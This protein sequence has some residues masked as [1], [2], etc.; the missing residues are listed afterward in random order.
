M[1]RNNKS[2]I[3]SRM[4]KSVLPPRA[5][6]LNESNPTLKPSNSKSAKRPRSPTNQHPCTTMLPQT[7]PSRSISNNT[8]H[9]AP[10]N[11]NFEESPRPNS[12][13]I[14]PNSAH[15]Q[16]AFSARKSFSNSEGRIQHNPNGRGTDASNSR[17]VWFRNPSIVWYRGHDLRVEDHP[18]LLAAAQRGGPVVSLF[19]WDPSDEFSVCLGDVKKWWLRQSLL[20]LERHLNRLGST[21]FA[22]VGDSTE[23]LRSVISATGADAVF[24]N[25]RYEPDLLHRDERLRTQLVS[26]GLT[27]ESFKSELIVEPWELTCSS[28]SPRFQDF[29]SY[30]PRWLNLPSPPLPLPS[31][32]RLKRLGFEVVSVDINDLGLEVS[33]HV[34]DTLAEIWRPGNSNGRSVLQCF[35]DE[36]F[37]SFGN[38]QKRRNAMGTSRLS[39]YIRFGEISPR[40]LF[41]SVLLHVTKTGRATSQKIVNE[42]AGRGQA[43]YVDLN[44]VDVEGNAPSRSIPS[45]IQSAAS[46]SSSIRAFLKNLCLRDF[47][48]HTLFHKP[49]FDTEPLIPEFHRFPWA[50]NSGS[51]AAW[52]NGR[53]GYPIVDAA[54][55]NLNCTGWIHNRMRFLLAS[56]LTKQLL[57]PWAKGLRAFYELL[58]DGDQA[59]NALGW[60][61]T[62]GSNTDAFPATY[63][64]NPMKLGHQYNP[65][66]NYIRKWVPELKDLPTQYIHEPWKAPQQVLQSAGVKL[67]SSYPSRIILLSSARQRYYRVLWSMRKVLSQSK[68]SKSLTLSEENV[69]VTECP[70]TKKT[71]E[72]ENS[73]SPGQLD[74]LSSLWSLTPA[75][76]VDSYLFKQPSFE[77]QFPL[78]DS[79][80]LDDAAVTIP[81]GDQHES[82]GYTLL[83]A[84]GVIPAASDLAPDT[85]NIL[86]DHFIT[87]NIFTDVVE[88]SPTDR[89]IVLRKHEDQHEA[90]VSDDC[91]LENTRT[92]GNSGGLTRDLAAGLE[93]SL[94]GVEQLHQNKKMSIEQRRDFQVSEVL[95]SPP[96]DG[97]ISPRKKIR[98]ARGLDPVTYE[99]GS[100]SRTNLGLG[101]LPNGFGNSGGHAVPNYQP[102]LRAHLSPNSLPIVNKGSLFPTSSA[103]TEGMSSHFAMPANMDRISADIVDNPEMLPS[104]GNRNSNTEL[105]G[106]AALENSGIHF[107]HRSKF[108]STYGPPF[109]IPMMEMHPYQQIGVPSMDVDA[110]KSSNLLPSTF[111]S[112]PGGMYDPSRAGGSGVPLGFLPYTMPHV[113]LPVT[114][115]STMPSMHPSYAPL[116]IPQHMLSHTSIPV[117]PS[118]SPHLSQTMAVSMDMSQATPGA[119]KTNEMPTITKET[120]F[121][122]LA[123][124]HPQST[125]LDPAFR[126]EHMVKLTSSTGRVTE[127]FKG[128]ASRMKEIGS[129]NVNGH[130][131]RGDSAENLNERPSIEVGESQLPAGGRPS[132][133]AREEFKAAIGAPGVIKR[134]EKIIPENVQR[135]SSSHGIEGEI[136][137]ELPKSSA[138]NLRIGEMGT[139]PAKGKA[140]RRRPR[141]PNKPRNPRVSSSP[142]AIVPV[143]EHAMTIDA[144]QDKFK[145]ASTG[146]ELANGKAR[147]NANANGSKS[148]LNHSGTP[149]A[150]NCPSTLKDREEVL[151]SIMGQNDHEYRN[152]AKFLFDNYELTSNTDRRTSK[153]YVR[154]CNLKDYFHN[155]CETEKEKLKIY[156]IKSFFSKVLKLEVTGEWD[157]HNHG[158][159]RGPYVYGIRRRIT[160]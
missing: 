78:V 112:Y 120:G 137:A 64:V 25:R 7:L 4:R 155:Q 84:C 138:P 56:F 141:Q 101:G 24:W 129:N 95:S 42:G 31:P 32:P 30:F 123:L 81:N 66:G 40:R 9:A 50:K 134:N 16:N 118:P 128:R 21:L 109:F 35:L 132:E 143:G 111:G 76:P 145:V 12:T 96:D 85:L 39:P 26:M 135:Q 125:G 22:R 45:N 97:T 159:V 65:D 8:V 2:D 148:E 29:H 126:R 52:C 3:S 70:P 44:A 146:G 61:W 160:Q 121:A 116:H 23:Q 117:H 38:V 37:R 99:L 69:T 151:E 15:T 36:S 63:I 80:Y 10:K 49:D 20:Q 34:S 139:P 90:F 68:V 124:P 27:A 136:L 54:M 122:D 55:R 17:E 144:T 156:R 88:V 6:R 107:A 91:L 158:G 77:N 13:A 104:H 11:N 150:S 127:P 98:K 1:E 48:Y 57:L 87:D 106:E 102:A 28:S 140:P 153:E 86:S 108:P 71:E 113:P 19:I 73:S 114:T 115:T 60:Q 154:L 74:L 47:A 18:A 5:D 94:P 130:G 67:G 51:F 83:S 72:D 92:P 149:S 142:D 58:V 46:T 59:S 93:D 79:A 157:R 53:T 152:F 62:A 100:T 110:A 14:T 89:N 147:T 41:F 82:I 43:S 33:Q 75:E 131:R 119:S 133:P 105:D 103:H